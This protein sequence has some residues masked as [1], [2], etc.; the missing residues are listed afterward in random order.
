M[1]HITVGTEVPLPMHHQYQ[2]FY[3]VLS[4][5]LETQPVGA[6]FHRSPE[7]FVES[8]YGQPRPVPVECLWGF[9]EA[10]HAVLPSSITASD[11]L[12][13]QAAMLRHGWDARREGRTDHPPIH[14][15]EGHTV[16]TRTVRTLHLLARTEGAHGEHV[17]YCDMLQRD[18]RVTAKRLMGLFCR[19]RREGFV[20]WDVFANSGVPRIHADVA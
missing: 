9:S 10:V 16:V 7:E 4:A 20:Y 2:L 18:I 17:I 11:V 6:V 1:F 15:M 8:I 3:G 12:F 13:T 5:S 14:E 19:W